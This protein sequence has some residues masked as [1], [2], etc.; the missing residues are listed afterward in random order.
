MRFWSTSPALFALFSALVQ[1]SA[2]A[3]A[4]TA[5]ETP[6]NS[7]P[8]CTATSPT[9][10]NFFDLRPLIRTTEK[11]SADT[12]WVAKGLD[13]NAN[14][15]IN[16]CAPVLADVT[17]VEGIKGDAKKN[18]SAFYEK[19][20]EMYSIGSVSTDLHFRGRKLVIEYTDGSPCPDA[21]KLR[22]STLMSLMCD[23]DML[24]KAAVSFVGQANECAYFF[25]VRTASAC[26]TVKIQALGPVS[27]FGIIGLVAAI[28]YCAGGCMYQRSVMHARG[29]R[30][31]PHYHAWAGAIGFIWSTANTVWTKFIECLPLPSSFRRS[32]SNSG[33]G[34]VGG[35]GFGARTVGGDRI[36]GGRS[37]V[38]DENQLID[39]LDEDWGD[40]P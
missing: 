30:Q 38:E 8:P 13:Y 3:D 24:Q 22:K 20:G 2:A 16:I 39:E 19:D 15:T 5:P 40:E 37:S 7:D 31:I 27:V 11:K 10:G 35:S 4:P 14:F 34:R 6:G 26:P 29:W 17:Q 18:V 21:P 33:Y 9:S 23:R 28:V 12:D 25:E 32:R 1:V 36:G